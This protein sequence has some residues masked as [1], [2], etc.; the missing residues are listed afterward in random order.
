M[1]TTGGPKLHVPQGYEQ[2]CAFLGERPIGKPVTVRCGLEHLDAEGDQSVVDSIPG[3][4]GISAIS[5]A[6]P[7]DPD[8]PPPAISIPEVRKSIK[9]KTIRPPSQS[10]RLEV[11]QRESVEEV[12][13]C[14]KRIETFVK[15]Y[16]EQCE[17][18]KKYMEEVI[19][20]QRKFLRMEERKTAILQELLKLER[21][22]NK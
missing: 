17:E 22:K 10:Q 7:S 9:R 3:P 11:L 19:E 1:K 14:G 6:E 2:M 12:R 8:D 16:E 15:K 20:N 4:S 5:S 21:E 18:Q 13:Q